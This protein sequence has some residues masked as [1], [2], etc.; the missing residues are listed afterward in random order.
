MSLD[1]DK[2]AV[3]TPAH[4]HFEQGELGL[5]VKMRRTP[6]QLLADAAKLEAL[7][8]RRTRLTAAE[9][10]AAL[11]WAA[12]EDGQRYVRKLAQRSRAIL[13]FPG[14]NGY[15]LRRLARA[16]MPGSAPLGWMPPMPS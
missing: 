13:S 14:S 9:I 11:G 3:V 15:T 5:I 6:Q 10:C 1:Y 4:E 12:D 8:D 2:P 16:P 7:L